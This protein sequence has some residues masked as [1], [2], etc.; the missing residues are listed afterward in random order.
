MLVDLIF[1]SDQEIEDHG[2]GGLQ[3]AAN[4]IAAETS[5]MEKEGKNLVIRGIASPIYDDDGEIAGAIESITDITEI[6]KKETALQISEAWFRAILENIGSATMIADEDATIL[7]V[8]PAFEKLVGFTKEEIEQTR[9]WTEFIFPDD[10]KRALDY[11]R[12]H[13]ISPE[14]VPAAVEFR[15]I[16]WDGQVRDGYITV[17]AI[18]GTTKTVNS[19][20]DITERKQSE[21]AVQ[22]ANKKLNYFSSVT[23]HDILNH[24]TALKGNLEL[25]KELVKDPALL[26]TIGKELVSADAIQAL[27]MFTQDYQDIGINPP[28]WQDLKR[29]ILQGCN[30]IR[31]KGITLSVDIEGV[32]I[33]ADLLLRKVFYHLIENARKYGGKVQQIRFSYK[34]SYE[35]LI[36]VCEDD[37][38]GIPPEAKEKI[39]SR[40]Y[41]G[42]TG[43][44]MYLSRE[45]LSITGISIAETGI[46]GQGARFEIRV[47]R[48]A[49]R[50]TGTE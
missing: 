32:E 7:Y 13:S 27:I 43:L 33:S 47:P 50:F 35:E 18:P 21:E 25:S 12:R 9:K 37:G 14:K 46:H 3:R 45:I 34:E 38:T 1:D 36:I 40:Q 20:L 28:E 23:R 5:A 49:Y 8:N 2:Y 4:S 48:G 30:G 6:K 42:N 19:I 26:K 44:D 10:L 22:R 17:T 39:F 15:Y 41:F 11:Y 31:L 16:R 24:L 29:T